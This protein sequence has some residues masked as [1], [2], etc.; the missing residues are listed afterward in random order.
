MKWESEYPWLVPK[1]DNNEVVGMLCSLC[2][3]HK[4]TGKY[5]HSKVW[6]ETPCICLRKDSIRRHSLSLQH[7]E[8]TDK[9]LCRQQSIRDGGIAQA[10]QTQAALNKVAIKVA[11]ECLYWLVKSEMPHTSLYGPLV[12]AV[13]FMGCGQLRNL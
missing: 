5:N 8:A 7:K 1:K 10:F 4:C 2:M 9:E 12:Q 3:K 11:M 13:E 6:G